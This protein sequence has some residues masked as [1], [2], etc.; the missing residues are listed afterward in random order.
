MR[1]RNLS[2][3]F[4]AAILTKVSTKRIAKVIPL[5]V[6]PFSEL[7]PEKER[8]KLLQ[9]PKIAFVLEIGEVLLSVDHPTFSRASVANF[10]FTDV[11]CTTKTA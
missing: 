11:V 4:W 3:D 7:L 2:A 9:I 8:D 10:C 5:R 6:F 1:C